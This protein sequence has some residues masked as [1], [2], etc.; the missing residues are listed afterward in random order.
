MPCPG[1]VHHGGTEDTE[2]DVNQLTEQVI[3]AAIE[4]HKALGPGLLESAYEE[5]LSRELSLRGVPFERQVPRSG[6]LQR[7]KARLRLPSG[8]SGRW[9]G[10]CGGQGHKGY[11]TDPRGTIADVPLVGHVQGWPAHQFQRAGSQGRRS[12]AGPIGLLCALRVS[13]VRGR[14][15]TC[16]VKGRCGGGLRN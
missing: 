14:A 13:V 6:R 3:G 11:R 8:L 12:P 10:H 4:V 16:S 7:N 5:C 9:G 1:E 15:R 2:M